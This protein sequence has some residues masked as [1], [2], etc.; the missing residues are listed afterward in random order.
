MSDMQE[1]LQSL[2]VVGED[3]VISIGKAQDQVVVVL[4]SLIVW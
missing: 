3:K 2:L 4:N 1:I